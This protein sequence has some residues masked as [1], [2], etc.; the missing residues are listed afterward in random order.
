MTMAIRIIPNPSAS[1]RSPLL[2]S[3]A[4]VVV[5]TRVTPSMFPPTII[6]APTS[7]AARPN[8]ARI[9]VSSENRVSQSSVSAALKRPAPSERSDDREDQD[10]LR[11]D[12]RRWREKNSQRAERTRTRKQKVYEQSHHDRRQTH[13][14]V[15]HHDHRLPAAKTADRDRGAQRQAQQCCDHHR[16]QAHAQAEQ[17][18]LDKLG[19]EPYQQRER[20]AQGFRHARL[21]VTVLQSV[22]IDV[23]EVYPRTQPH[24]YGA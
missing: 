17:N 21:M 6:T 20:S 15:Q 18:D 11:K 10:R 22:L 4:M 19:V 3:S 7:A 5:I 12:H 8:P 24:E 9:V 2:V 13:E 1:G 16:R 23:Y 14:G